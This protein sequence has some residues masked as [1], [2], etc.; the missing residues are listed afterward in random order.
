[1]LPSCIYAL[2][3]PSERAPSVRP[4]SPSLDLNQYLVFP[5]EMLNL[6]LNNLCFSPPDVESHLQEDVKVSESGSWKCP[7]EILTFTFRLLWLSFEVV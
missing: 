2:Y 4:R 7:D 5:V 1:M 6:K 3:L